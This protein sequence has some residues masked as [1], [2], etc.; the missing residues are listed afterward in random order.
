MATVND[1]LEFFEEF[2]PA[3]SAMD[4]DNVGLLVGCKDAEVSRALVSLDITPE[5]V[6]EAETLG[7]ELIISHHPV[8]FQPLKRLERGSAPYLL[9]QKDIAAICMHTNL[10]LSESFGV[11]LCLAEAIGL[12]NTVRSDKGECV[13]V[14]ELEREISSDELAE[15]VKFALDCKGLRYTAACDR[16]KRVA[17]ASG[18][19]GSEV[20]AAAAEGC[21]A[22]VTGE[23]KHHELNAANELGISVIEAGH[24]KS[25]NIVILP[26]AKKLGKRFDDIIFTKSKK[27]DDKVKFC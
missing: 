8:I 11:N 2:A 3:D 25:E 1:I 16:V 22:L 6:Y 20:F 13:F 9:A 17:V 12:K 4:F 24:F 19:G 23:I 7:C 18:S 15:Q 10:D 5:V 14:G 21:G 26:L 27:Y